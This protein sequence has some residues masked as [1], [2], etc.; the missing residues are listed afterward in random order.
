MKAP[1]FR[2]F[3][4]EL[5]AVEIDALGLHHLIS[6]PRKAKIRPDYSADNCLPLRSLISENSSGR[7][8][9]H[10]NARSPEKIQFVQRNAD[11]AHQLDERGS[12]EAEGNDEKYGDAVFVLKS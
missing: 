3:Q 1:G 12:K 9:S 5:S 11:F 4:I 8:E 7:T 10:R 6:T 2:G